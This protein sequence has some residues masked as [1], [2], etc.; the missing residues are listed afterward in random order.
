[1]V[2]QTCLDNVNM[3]NFLIAEYSLPILKLLGHAELSF[4][5]YCFEAAV[6]YCFFPFF[7]ALSPPPFFFE[8]VGVPVKIKIRYVGLIFS[9]VQCGKQNKYML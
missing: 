9:H 4:S 3:L 1:M 2:Q 8:W 7:P 5:C 6:N